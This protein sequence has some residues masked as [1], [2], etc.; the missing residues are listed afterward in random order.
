MNDHDREQIAR[1][2][3]K[4][5]D[6]SL[7]AEEFD[8]FQRML[9]DQPKA[10][11]LYLDLM[12]Q[13]A[14]LQLE[15]VHLSVMSLRSKEESEKQLGRSRPLDKN[16]WVS[17]FTLLAASFLLMAWWVFPS[18]DSQRARVVAQIS[19]S[20]D[21]K[22]GECSLPT[23]VGSQ[24]RPGR[25]KIDRG[26]ATI[27]FASGAEVTLESPA[28]LEIE[29][30]LAGRLLAGTAVVEVPDSAHGFTLTT[31]TVVAI[32][33]GT[34]FAITVDTSSQTSSIEVLEGE[35]EVQ[36][37]TSDASLRLKQKQ[38]VT[39]S[40]TQLSDSAVSTGEANLLGSKPSVS[41]QARLLR[42]TT[43]YGRGRDVS[44][45]RSQD[46]DVRKN[47]H[48]ELILVKNP[49]DGYERFARKAYFRFDLASLSRSEIV[50]AKFALTLRPSG[51]GFASKVGDCEFVVYGL[52]DE[53]VDD[54]SEE[55]LTW[56]TAPA[57]LDG[58]AEVDTELVRELG[59]FVVRRGV[60]HGPVS[61]EGDELVQFL[62][63][64]TNQS[65]TLIVVRETSESEPG[66]LVHGFTNRSSPVGTPPTLFVRANGQ[67]EPS[68]LVREK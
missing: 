3:E 29:S 39:A 56:K 15:G 32:D 22:W 38:R 41:Q 21:A 35:V 57:N 43:A 24:L 17:V 63:A 44:V 52:T 19:S 12:H 25:L 34:A 48:S 1:W 13:N 16:L 37:R 50:S 20:S 51:L 60:Q 2:V 67:T 47:S 6:G 33:Y 5:L 54:W 31:P 66:G 46:D 18:A 27:R 4:Q 55:Q 58:A 45:S 30:P 36:H 65:A 42:V 62:N 7:A 64:D 40:A 49:Y 9:T 68:G 11:E 23:A 8:Q 53:S 26:L 10:R 28:E 14:H 59:R 61:V